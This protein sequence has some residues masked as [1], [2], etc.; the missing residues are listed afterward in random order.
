MKKILCAILAAVLCISLFSCGSVDE[1]DFEKRADKANSSLQNKKPAVTA[2]ET[3]APEDTEIPDITETPAITE[4]PVITEVPTVTEAPVVTE[5]PEVTEAP[6][7]TEAPAP[8]LNDVQIYTSYLTSGNLSK[9]ISD[10]YMQ[11]SDVEIES[12]LEDLNGDGLR[13]LLL[14]VT[15]LQSM[16]VRGN[17]FATYLFTIVN[18]TPVL[19]TDEYYGGGSM[20][21]PQLVIVTDNTTG[22]RHAARNGYFRD[23]YYFNEA[24]LT[25]YDIEG[26]AVREITTFSLGR[27]TDDDMGREYINK[28]KSETNI[29]TINDGELRYRKIDDRYVD[30]AEYQQSVSRFKDYGFTSTKGTLKNPL[31]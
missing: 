14:T 30:E 22:K 3:R 11:P 21:G 12:Y 31:G 16:G 29:Y 20:G 26:G 15:D 28:V 9:L 18:G 24:S 6:I 25:P 19:L 7:V 10:S 27:I 13:E 8:A 17:A 23:G 5:A 2:V 4:A 1:I